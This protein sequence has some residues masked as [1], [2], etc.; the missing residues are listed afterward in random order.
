MD[1]LLSITSLLLPPKIAPVANSLAHE[2]LAFNLSAIG[3]PPLASSSLTPQG[4]ALRSW[5][6]FAVMEL[7]D[8]LD[9]MIHPYGALLAV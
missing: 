5:S 4:N 3:P 9:L 8:K 7:Q 1:T 6:G 2:I